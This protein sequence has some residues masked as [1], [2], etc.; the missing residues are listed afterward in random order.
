MRTAATLTLALLLGVFTMGA[1][2]ALSIS[3]SELA[4]LNWTYTSD[5]STDT[6]GNN[7]FKTYGSGYAI[8]GGFLYVVVQTSFPQ[9]G[10]TGNDSYK[11]GVHIDTGDLYINV[12]G[13]FQS[14]TGSVYGIATTSHSNVVQQAYSGQ[15][16]TSVVAGSLYSNATFADG[17]YEQ[18]QQ[19]YPSADP[20]DGD[21]SNKKNSYPTLIKTGTRVSGD[22]SGVSYQTADAADAW[23]YE[24]YYKVSLTALGITDGMTIQTFWAMECG[25]DGTQQSF[26]TPTV[27][28]PTTVAL[29]VAGIS[30]F[31]VRRRSIV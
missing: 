11:N 14:K 22:V 26:S 21:G 16:W 6:S 3:N 4:S 23:D 15:T 24:I 7:E 27:P 2:N 9:A 5:S 20:D 8:S 19:A 25:N 30:A 18:Y 29:M 31:V 13:T 10:T 12:G 28:E 17:T 1:A